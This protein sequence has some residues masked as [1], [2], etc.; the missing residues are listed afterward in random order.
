M[1]KFKR[2]ESLTNNFLDLFKNEE[3]PQE[4]TK[5]VRHIKRFKLATTEMDLMVVNKK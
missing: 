2:Q 4:E 3:N 1:S 5:T